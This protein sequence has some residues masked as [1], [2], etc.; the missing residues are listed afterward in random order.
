MASILVYEQDKRTVER[1]HDA[2]GAEGWQVHA[3]ADAAAVG[4]ALAAGT[5]DLVLIDVEAADADT[6][7]ASLGRGEAP[8]VL[9]MVGETAGAP[10]GIEV[11]RK[12]FEEV[13]LRSAVRSCLGRSQRL[14]AQLAAEAA[15]RAGAQLT[16]QELFGDMIAEVEEEVAA[17]APPPRAAAVD[18]EVERRLEQSLSG[19]LA[20][21]KAA[22]GQGIAARARARKADADADV[23]DLLTQ[24]LSGLGVAPRQRPRA[25]VRAEPATPPEP[26]SVAPPPAS[27]PAA[28][29]AET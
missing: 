23:D 28:T 22:A 4:Q 16:S 21:P 12:P 13:A 10:P 17:S 8:A 6:L 1:I 5:P 3:V 26:P 25:T 18:S 19:V 14:A 7:L 20:T 9:A 29:P 15:A 2:L 11:L 24:T 27:P